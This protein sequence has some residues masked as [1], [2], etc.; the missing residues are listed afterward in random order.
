MSILNRQLFSFARG[1]TDG[2]ARG[3][4]NVSGKL[5]QPLGRHLF[6]RPHPIRAIVGAAVIAPRVKFVF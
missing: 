6:E 5:L 3:G 4:L 1:A 2:N